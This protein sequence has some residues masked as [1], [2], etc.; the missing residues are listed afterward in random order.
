L[1]QRIRWSDIDQQYRRNREQLKDLNFQVF[2]SFFLI[3]FPSFFQKFCS[4]SGFMRF[5]PSAPWLWEDRQSE[6][7]LFDCRVSFFK[8]G[9]RYVKMPYDKPPKL[10]IRTFDI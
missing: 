10:A 1:L 5:F 4:D 8:I 2:F 9:H 6:L 3:I 7:D